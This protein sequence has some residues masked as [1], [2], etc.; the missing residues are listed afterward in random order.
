M[1]KKKRI[2]SELYY[3]RETVEIYL[4]NQRIAVHKRDHSSKRYITKPQH[5]PE[6]HRRYLERWN[7]EKIIALAQTKGVFVARFV[8][9]LLDR[10][11]HTEQSYN[12]CRG[13][14][15]LSRQYGMERLDKACKKTLK[16]QQRGDA[17]RTGIIC[18]SPS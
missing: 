8:E 2:K 10:E 11:K 18:R 13:I 15:F 3:T 12:T 14:I 4:K 9:K 7:P 16:K 6:A 1:E 17:R 5:M